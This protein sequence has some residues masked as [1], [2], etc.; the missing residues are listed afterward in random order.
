MAT[1]RSGDRVSTGE[2]LGALLLNDPGR[3]PREVRA[4]LSTGSDS[5]GGFLVTP[6]MSREFI[7]LARVA[8]VCIAAGARTVTME[9]SKLILTKLVRDPAPTWR[10]EFQA[11]MVTDTGV[12]ADLA[13]A[14]D[15]R[16]HRAGLD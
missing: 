11:Q 14:E 10:A 1:R 12:R 9:A 7:D 15:G 16:D 3:L 13:Q 6:E 2:V 4:E 8:S 5:G